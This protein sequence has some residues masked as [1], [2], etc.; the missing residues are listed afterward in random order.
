MSGRG[1]N[2]IDP[3]AF[4]PGNLTPAQPKRQ[5][6]TTSPNRAIFQR[7]LDR[8]KRARQFQRLEAKLVSQL[9]VDDA[10]A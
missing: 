2:I 9:T 3:A 1:D 7:V 5:L 6:S 8:R 10:R 4:E